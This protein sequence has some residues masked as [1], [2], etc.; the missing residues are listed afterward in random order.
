MLWLAALVGLGVSLGLLPVF[1]RGEVPAVELVAMRVTLGAAVL[2][3]ALWL[4]ERPR[5]SRGEFAGI[6]VVAA[7]L[8][9]HW[10]TFFLAV[11][12]TT[13]AVAL[14]AVYLGPVLAAVAAGPF[15]GERAGIRAHLG[16]GLALVG[17]L[18]VVRPGAGVT[19]PGLAAGVASGIL[20]GAFM[21][22]GKRLVARIGGLTLAAW[23]LVFAAA[24]LAP[25]TVR[26]AGRWAVEWPRFLLLGV[27]FTG[28]AGVLYWSAMRRLP[29]TTVGVVMYL[30]PTSAVVWSAVLLDEPLDLLG[31]LGVF[32]VVGG[33]ILA[34]LEVPEEVPAGGPA[35]L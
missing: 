10:I 3:P 21:I 12:L 15:L 22:V 34:S 29:V 31:W 25:F 33:G 35:A 24:F 11:Q 14:A 1:V 8:T 30:E 9:L 5:V 2:V 4:T 28:L 26:A 32:A 17:T 6:A 13:V 27:V 23:E 18:V 20:F 19:A 16:L 7:L